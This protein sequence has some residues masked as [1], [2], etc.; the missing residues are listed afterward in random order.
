MGQTSAAYRLIIGHLDDGDV[1]V[2]FSE[3]E[4]GHVHLLKDIDQLH[5]ED[6]GVELDRSLGV[7]YSK[8]NVSHFLDFRHDYPSLVEDRKHTLSGAGLQ[9]SCLRMA[10]LRQALQHE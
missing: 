2:A 10:G 5:A 9:G 7:P 8:D 1:M 3:R 4:K 6:L